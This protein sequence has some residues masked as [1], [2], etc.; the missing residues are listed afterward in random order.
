MKARLE[1][2]RP[3]ATAAFGEA[4]SFDEPL[5]RHTLYKIGGPADLF[6]RAS[7]VGLLRAAV[8]FAAEHGLALQA[9]GH[10]SNLLVPDDGVRG[11]VVRVGLTTARVDDT[12][13]SVGAGLALPQAA[14]LAAKHALGGLEFAVGIPG[15]VGGALVMNAGCHGHEI[16]ALV[17]RVDVVASDGV[18]R[19]L[20]RDE[21]GFAYRTSRLRERGAAIAGATL[22]L[23]PDDAAAIQKRMGEHRAWRAETQPHG[24]PSAGCVFQNPPDEAAGRLIDQAG[25]KGLRVGGAEVSTVHANFIINRD[26][27][28]Y[29]DV[30]RLI[31][32]VRERV[33]ARFGVRL[34]LELVDLGCSIRSS[35]DEAP[36]PPERNEETPH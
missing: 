28:T 5:A 19:T 36:A 11:L 6:V 22:R 8:E 1:H 7:R 3:A 34:E 26:G 14:A 4:V 15:T 18:V 21:C 30:T 2:L 35:L 31:E 9:I 12:V 32:A 10:G 27:A 25:C 20:S 17:E 24:R 33:E 13:L 29:A 16:G 23:A